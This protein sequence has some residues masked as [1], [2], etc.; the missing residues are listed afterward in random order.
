[1]LGLLKTADISHGR[2]ALGGPGLVAAL[3]GD[4][5]SSRQLQGKSG[6]AQQALGFVM[7]CL[8]AGVVVIAIGSQEIRQNL[9]IFFKESLLAFEAGEILTRLDRP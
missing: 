5:V 3:P 8:R 7:N 9:F 6:S 2:E 4:Q 1:M